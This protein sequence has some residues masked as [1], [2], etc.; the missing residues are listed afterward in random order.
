MSDVIRAGGVETTSRTSDTKAERLMRYKRQL[1]AI[2]DP[3]ETLYEEAFSYIAPGYSDWE[4]RTSSDKNDKKLT[5]QIYNSRPVSAMQTVVAGLQGYLT[6]QNSRWTNY[7]FEDPKIMEAPRVR[8]YL[9]ACEEH[10]DGV[11]RQNGFYQALDEGYPQLVTAGTHTVLL[12]DDEKDEVLRIL[13]LHPKHVYM[14]TDIYGKV[15]TW[16]LTFSYTLEQIEDQ[17]PGKLTQEQRARMADNPHTE[18][19]VSIFIMPRHI[20][21]VTKIDR[22]NKPWAQY[23]VLESTQVLLDEGGFDEPPVITGRWSRLSNEV[24][25]RGWGLDVLSD[26]LR[27]N[28]LTKAELTAAQWAVDPAWAYPSDIYEEIEL[29]PGARVPYFNPAKQVTP[30]ALGGNYPIG[31]DAKQELE[32]SINQQLMVDFFLSLMQAQGKTMTATEVLERQGEK[33]AI[34]GTMINRTENETII[35]LLARVWAYEAKKGRL[36]EPPRAVVE[37]QAQLKV[38]FVGP[39]ANISKRFHTHQGVTQALTT[40]IPMV[41]LSQGRILDIV[42]WDEVGRHVLENDASFPQKAINDVRKVAEIRAAQAQA[43]AQQQQLQ[44]AE[45]LGKA[46]PGLAEL[47]K[48]QGEQV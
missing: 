15:N 43:M 21:D 12:Q 40:F 27:L 47:Q 18:E 5:T 29:V 33:A 11:L 30:I 13:S 31:K 8:E 34:L 32:M 22:M 45:V 19:L 46:G 3:W 1:E 26:V 36:P 2:R 37:S 28:T 7:R 48:A 14:H 23:V 41:E 10:M 44:Q 20:R 24:Y 25:G 16:A 39:L 6:P 4:I 38:E 17:Y 35:P 42:D 9:Q